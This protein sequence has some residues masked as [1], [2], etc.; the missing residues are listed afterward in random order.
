MKGAL[1]DTK[2]RIAITKSKLY[3][4]LRYFLIVIIKSI[5]TKKTLTGLN[6]SGYGDWISAIVSFAQSASTPVSKALKYPD[7]VGAF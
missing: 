2:T 4:L 7:N 3:L 1:I 5:V 6:N